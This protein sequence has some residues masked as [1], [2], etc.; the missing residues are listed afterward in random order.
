V[1]SVKLIVEG[2]HSATI[3]NAISTQSAK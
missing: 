1:E 3:K 2:E